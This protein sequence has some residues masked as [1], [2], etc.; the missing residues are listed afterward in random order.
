[1]NGSIRIPVRLTRGR[2]NR[3]VIQERTIDLASTPAPDTGGL[4][5]SD[6]VPRI[7]R[8]MALAIHIDELVR[9]GEIKDYAEAA[10]LGNIT[11]A[12][13][14]QITN[15]LMLSPEIQEWLLFLT[16]TARGRDPVVE[17]TLRPACTE[18]SWLRQRRVLE[19]VVA[20]KILLS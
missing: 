11:R 1:L 4:S 3:L 2:G 18:R 19:S 7:S 6:R 14:S 16:P 5:H 15:L 20:D 13:M 17:Q 8:L 9:S 10:R 12:R